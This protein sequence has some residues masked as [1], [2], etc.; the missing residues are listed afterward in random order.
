MQASHS[1]L[2]WDDWKIDYL[3]CHINKKIHL[4]SVTKLRCQKSA[5]LQR[6]LWITFRCSGMKM[7]RSNT[8]LFRAHWRT[9]RGNIAFHCQA[10]PSMSCGKC[11]TNLSRLIVWYVDQLVM[12]CLYVCVVWQVDNIAATDGNRRSHPIVSSSTVAENRWRHRSSAFGTR[13]IRLFF[14][15][16]EASDAA[17]LF[18]PGPSQLM[19]MYT[20]LSACTN[21]HLFIFS[22][23][24]AYA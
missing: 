14:R 6:L 15:A 9:I 19:S 20:G 17:D 8:T 22:R 24:L 2:W 23:N 7:C 1:P 5:G 3:K 4:D 12:I 11:C 10:S 13:Q 16:A 18:V 21:I